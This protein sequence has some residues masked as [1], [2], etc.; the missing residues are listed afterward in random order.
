MSAFIKPV[1]WYLLLKDRKH[2]NYRKETE[3]LHLTAAKTIPRVQKLDL[4]PLVN[5]S[6]I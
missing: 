1:L 2:F 3:E 6:E 4:R 5:V